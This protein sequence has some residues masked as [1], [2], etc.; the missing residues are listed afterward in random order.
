MKKYLLFFTF[1]ILK[2]DHIKSLLFPVIFFLSSVGFSQD[3]NNLIKTYF[4]D[5]LEKLNLSQADVAEWRLTNKVYSKQSNVTHVYL[6]Q[7]YKGIPV[8]NAV[9]NFTIK[10]HK[11]MFATNSFIKDLALKINTVSPVL[12]PKTAITQVAS[13]LHL[14]TPTD[15]ELLEE[16]GNSA[17]VFS[18]SGISQERIP[19]ELVYQPLKEGAVKL[20]WLLNIYQLDGIHW[21]NVRI[22]ATKGVILEKNDWGVSC[23]F[24]ITTGTHYHDSKIVKQ[25]SQSPVIS[26]K[27]NVSFDG[28]AQYNVFGLPVES[29]NHGDRSLI[30]GS[31][32]TLAS[33][34]GWH[35]TDG[36]TGPEYTITRG[37]NVY[38]QLDAD[39]DND[40][41]GYAPDGG[42]ELVFNYSLEMNNKPADSYKDVSITNLFYLNNVMHDIWYQY[43]FDEVSGNFQSNNYGREAAL[44]F[45]PTD[46]DEVVADSQDA[47]GKNNANFATPPDGFKPRMQMFLWDDASMSINSGSLAGKYAITDSNFTIDGTIETAN[48]GAPLNEN[49][50]TA[51]LVLMN[52]DT[53]TPINGCS[54]SGAPIAG[55][56]GKI[57]V[58]RRGDCS[59]VNKI[60]LAEDN[61]A[62]GVIVVN[63]T[64]GN[65]RMGGATEGINIPAVSITLGLGNSII[66]AL[67]NSENINVSLSAFD[68]DGSFDNGIIAHE[69]GH[70]ISNRLIGGGDNSNCMSNQEQLGEGWSDYFGM[71]ITMLPSNT[72]TTVRGVGTFA[73]GQAITGNGIRRYPYTTDMAVNPF[74]F[75]DVKDQG[76]EGDVSPHGVGSIWATMLWDLHW[77][78]INIYGFDSDMYNG[79][80]GNNKTMSLVIEG[81]KLTPC[82]SGFIGARDAIL[83]ADILLNNGANQCVIWEVFARRGLGYS[84]DS[85]DPDS[86]TDQI[87]AFDLPPENVLSASSCNTALNIKSDVLKIFTIYPN[88]ATTSINISLTNEVKNANTIIYDINGRQVYAQ[89]SDLEGTVT[90][91]TE[92]LSRGIYIL[93]INNEVINYSQKIVIN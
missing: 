22:D 83:A 30:T 9:S 43:G 62:V 67:S 40:T 39:N 19:V 78:M 8:Y 72:E 16:K 70:G 17:Y 59:F 14:G 54:E 81:L 74:T 56:D 3:Y 31:H 2:K 60:K 26:I 45:P 24:D 37:N 35:D 84:A 42:T 47:G 23:N 12:Q 46:G 49:P 89:K 79:T 36:A 34:F 18:K 7:T 86:F 90:I 51:D 91:N 41:D 25:P 11:V 44:T 28:G 88:P 58:I 69:Y 64:G 80:G 48:S 63:N 32:N 50:V 55:L 93:K 82:S 71:A 20:S 29:P 1:N 92:N 75:K 65:I 10:D 68:L 76:S 66:S 87:E 21:W 6:Q 15:L 57:V 13:A 53:E 73:S 27:K 77:K 61:N 85:G 5:N 4:S 38:A 52:D 33:P